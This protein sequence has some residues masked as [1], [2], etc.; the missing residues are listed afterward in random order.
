MNQIIYN[1]Q[2][3]IKVCFNLRYEIALCFI[4]E[5]KVNT[6]LQIDEYSSIKLKS[7]Q[8]FSSW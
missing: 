1:L 7:E 4:T 8:N 3:S 2:K 5:E 6:L